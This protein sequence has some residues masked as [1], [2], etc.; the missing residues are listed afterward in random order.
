MITTAVLVFLALFLFL[1]LVLL[2]V[3]TYNGLVSR[4]GAVDNAWAQADAQLGRRH[5]LAS[6]LVETMEGHAVHERQA[7]EAVAAARSQAVGARTPA[8]QVTAENLLSGALRSLLAVAEAYPDLK[9]GR[10]FAKLQEELA[11]TESR[12]AYFRQCYNDA[13]L[14]YNNAIQMTPANIVASVN[15]FSQSEYFRAPDEE[16]SPVRAR[17]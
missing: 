10:N 11:A 9:A 1:L 8:D 2:V 4:R 13:A 16:R 12:I 15:G 3:S 7:L 5:D 14:I 6:I 17:F